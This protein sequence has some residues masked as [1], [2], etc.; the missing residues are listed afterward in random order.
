MTDNVDIFIAGGGIA[1]LAAAAGFGSLG[2]HVLCVEPNPPVTSGADEGADLRT[3]ALLQ[4][5]REILDAAG[6]WAKLAP[7][8][9]PLEV[10]RIVDAR[11]PQ[12]TA[13]KSREFRASDIS[14]LPFGWNVPNWVLRR[15][16]LARLDELPTVTFATGLHVTSLFT[17]TEMARVTLSDGKRITARL[18]VAADGR[19]SALRDLAGI[20][21]KTYRYGQ[22]AL[23]FAVTHETPHDN[24]STEIHRAGGPFTFVPL[25]DLDGRPRSAV[26]WMDDGATCQ[27]RMQLDAD[28]FAREATERSAQIYGPLT[29]VS[30]RSIWPI[31]SQRADELVGERL[32]LIAE[33]AHVVP[34][35]GAQG[36]NMSLADISTLVDLCRASPDTLGS[37]GMLSAYLK[38]RSND[39][40]LRVEGINALNRISQFDQPAL[41]TLREWGLGMLH[42]IPAVRKQTMRLGLGMHAARATGEKV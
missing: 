37:A 34:P 5:A 25:P 22:K 41:Q 33:A 24:V 4:P 36:L 19:H 7:H 21:V 38:A 27:R 13:H 32:A 40:R 3:T 17:R 2:L 31:I 29:L 14:D 30:Q 6:V 8:G 42:D 10:M 16:I 26:V 35:I 28:D 15:E 20:G 1:G 39:V 18:V 23:A 12:A 11:D 9:T